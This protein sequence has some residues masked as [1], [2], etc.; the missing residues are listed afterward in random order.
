MIKARWLRASQALAL[1]VMLA[2]VLVPPLALAQRAEIFT[3]GRQQF[4]ADLAAAG[5]DTVAYHTQSKAVPGTGEFRVN[6]KGAEWRFASQRHRDLFVADPDKY[7][8]QYGGWCA[9][10]VAAGVKATSDPLLFD[11]VGGR[12]YLN[13]STGTQASW[14]RDQA[15]MIQRGDQNWLRI[16]KQ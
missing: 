7:A 5:Y 11:L 6:W 2:A 14:R 9:F 3:G 15:G 13:Q 1:A 4:G 12:L 10:A 8:P 16:A